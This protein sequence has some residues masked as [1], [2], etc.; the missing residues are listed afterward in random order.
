METSVKRSDLVEVGFWRA[1]GFASRSFD[2]GEPMLDM[3][4]YVLH[5]SFDGRNPSVFDWI[6]RDQDPKE[7]ARVLSY[8][9]D[10]TFR[11]MSWL[12]DSTC[13]MCGKPNGCADYTDGKFIW[14]EGLAHYVRDHD[15]W[16]P[17]EFVQHALG[18]KVGSR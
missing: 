10:P 1:D 2:T 3:I 4:G 6:D 14:P 9:S 16:L 11:L 12:G 15:V 7:R 18:R 5:V 8:V 17:L 13:R